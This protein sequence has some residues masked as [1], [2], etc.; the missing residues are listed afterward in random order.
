M[1]KSQIKLLN[2][3]SARL[4]ARNF[5]PQHT[6]GASVPI[7]VYRQVITELERTKEQL[8]LLEEQNQQLLQ[9]NQELK[10]EIVKIVNT[11]QKLEQVIVSPHQ[12]TNSLPPTENFSTNFFPTQT[13]NYVKNTHS[14][15]LINGWVLALAIIMIMLTAFTSGFLLIRPI[16]YQPSP[17]Q[18]EN[19]WN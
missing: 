1:T 8:T 18:G 5:A 7:L 17:T 15:K 16:L 13:G 11:S 2:F 10:Q 19:N 14:Q 9:Q 6:S 4:S 12:Q 3:T